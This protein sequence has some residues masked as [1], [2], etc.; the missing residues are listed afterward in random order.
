MLV[1][2]NELRA[3]KIKL[4]CNK[5]IEN[6][7]LKANFYLKI[8]KKIRLKTIPCEKFEISKNHKPKV[9]M[10]LNFSRLQKIFA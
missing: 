8:L 3:Q 10:K 4:L 6:P 7:N 5:Y 9:N 2:A 1:N